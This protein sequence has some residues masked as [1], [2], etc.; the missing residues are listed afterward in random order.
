[1]PPAMD[2]IVTFEIS[3]Q[4]D[5]NNRFSVKHN[6][7]VYRTSKQE[8][9]VTRNREAARVSRERRREQLK[10]LEARVRQ[11]EES[12]LQLKQE[13]SELEVRLAPVALDEMQTPPFVLESTFIPESTL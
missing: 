5:H 10:I 6:V 1:M 13:N 4:E 11:L 2:V 12:N 9:R 3:G 7:D 8:L